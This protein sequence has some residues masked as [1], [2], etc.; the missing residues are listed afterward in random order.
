M[1]KP[2][3]KRPCGQAVAVYIED[4]LGRRVVLAGRDGGALSN[5]IVI[6]TTKA[7]L[8]RAAAV[9]RE[10]AD[11][12]PEGAPTAGRRGALAHRAHRG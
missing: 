10:M 1:T 9:L 11:E 7:E 4:G 3:D 12:L 6:A 2:H 8:R 5:P